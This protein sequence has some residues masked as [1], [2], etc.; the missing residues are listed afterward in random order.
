MKKYDLPAMPFYIG[1][2]KKDPAL[3]MLSREEKMIWLE[4]IFLMWESSER[5]YLTIK[6]KPYTI[7]M[8]SASLN[9]DN[10]RLNTMLTKFEEL[11][12]Y[13]RRETDNA[14]YSRKIINIIEISEKRKNAGKRGGNPV[15][16]NQRL[17]NRLTSKQKLAYSNAEIENEDENAIE[18]ETETDK[19]DARGKNEMPK[20]PEELMQITGFPSAWEDW[21]QHKKEIKNKLTPLAA[22][23][24]FTGLL[25]MRDP[26]G[27]IEYSIEKGWKGI[28]EPKNDEQNRRTYTRPPSRAEVTA[29]EFRTGLVRAFGEE[30][31]DSLIREHTRTGKPIS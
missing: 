18:T 25:K 24:C 3:S 13:S 8:L 26:V 14:I 16:V 2:W 15:L 19:G 17:N 22:K 23:K 12:I 30:G 31:A 11:D 1:D 7:E 9:L 4:M 21:I 6:G 28:Y 10:Q 5:G 27:A 20:P 29:D